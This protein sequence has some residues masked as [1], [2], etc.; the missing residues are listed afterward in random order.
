MSENLAGISRAVDYINESISRRSGPEASGFKPEVALV[1][2]SGLGGLTGDVRQFC[3]LRYSEIPGFASPTVPGH[4]GILVA[5]ELA[6]KKAIVFS[7]RVHTYEGVSMEKMVIPVRLARLLGARAMILTSAVGA[8]GRKFRPGDI[9]LIEDH[10]NFTG[11]N[12]L[13]GAH[14]ARFGE[15]FPDMSEC[16]SKRL[17]KLA[18]D[19]AKKSRLAVRRGVY[20]GV[21][22]P[23]YETPS[24]IRAFRKL[25]GDVVGMS[26]V[27]EAI[28]AR[29]MG[30]EVLALC[31]VS[32][33]AAGM[34]RNVLRH[35]EVLEVTG[36]TGQKLSGLLADIVRNL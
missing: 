13:R 2:G 12:P 28:A 11:E 24:E 15:R 31:M 26:V 1:L 10:I 16:Y 6:G 27:P 17:R 23:S 34:S 25:G 29:Q 8:I 3:T 35:D 32:N 20:F 9:V 14:D 7:G 19:L 5:G 21:S 18:L 36:R 22:G 33:R 4:G 30:M